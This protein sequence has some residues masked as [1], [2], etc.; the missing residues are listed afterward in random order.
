VKYFPLIWAGIWRKPARTIFTLLS[1]VVAFILF[2]VLMGFN[3]SID[4]IIERARLDR[5]NVNARYGGFMPRAY[6]E[7]VARMPGVKVVSANAGVF[8]TYQDPMNN[9]F[10][11]MMDENFERARPEQTATPEQLA[12][13]RHMRTGALITELM[14]AQ[15]G[16]KSGDR[17]AIET[18][19]P[20][21]QRRDGAKA[22]TFDIVGIIPDQIAATAGGMF[23][24]YAYLDEA[25][26]YNR[27]TV[28]FMSFLV[29]DPAHADEIAHM[30]DRRYAN[31]PVP[32]RS[33]VERNGAINA[34]EGT[35]NLKFVTI[36]VVG[37]ALF[38]V[39]FLTGN[40]L[41]Q[42][43][44]ERLNEFAVLKTLGYSDR[45]VTGLVLAE[46]ILPCVAGALL[47]TAAAYAIQREG[48][49]LTPPGINV[50]LPEITPPV[51]FYALCLALVVA[52]IS[53]WPAVRRLARLSI[54]DALSGR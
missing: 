27:G 37:A 6:A 29:N 42:S 7:E 41:T 45:S 35:V 33:T 43:V 14:A 18:P 23:G 19:A 9:V 1:V 4:R 15:Y 50:P 51:V 22:W 2:G 46:A 36:T 54:V 48:A 49:H 47:G 39:L 13:L 31:S 52:G 11:L 5:V 8:G 3:H 44:R 20:P 28:G 53:G 10:V 26:T 34:I 21:M 24:N 25:R 32:T 40:V 30:V 12:T 38:M 16:W 17:V